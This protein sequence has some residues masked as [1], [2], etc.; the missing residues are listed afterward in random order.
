MSAT[1]N[2]LFSIASSTHVHAAL[3]NA[4]RHDG[5]TKPLR[6]ATAL[7]ARKSRLHQ[8]QR[9]TSLT[10]PDALALGSQHAQTLPRTCVRENWRSDNLPGIKASETA[11]RQARDAISADAACYV[12]AR[13]L[14]SLTP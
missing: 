2:A 6:S 11:E 9:N 1:L 12:L 5:L 14:S 4:R 3:W 8:P 7:R 10:D 13:F